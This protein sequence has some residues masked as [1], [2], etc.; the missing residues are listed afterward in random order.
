MT[1]KQQ[2]Y[3]RAKEL[4]CTIIDDGYCVQIEAPDGYVFFGLGCH[5]S[6]M[7]I[8]GNGAWKKADIWQA[9]LDDYMELGLDPCDDPECDCH[10]GP[11]GPKGE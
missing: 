4:G 6:M 2:A 10:Y 11:V 3:A 9:L 1:I 5:C 8:Y 7:F